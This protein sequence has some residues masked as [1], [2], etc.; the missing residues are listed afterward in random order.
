MFTGKQPLHVELACQL[1]RD[2]RTAVFV[3]PTHGQGAVV[4]VPGE[5]V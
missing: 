4:G 1:A 3:G 5:S 2:A